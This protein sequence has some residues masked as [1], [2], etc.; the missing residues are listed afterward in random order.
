MVNKKDL[1]AGVACMRKTAAFL[2][3]WAD[4]LE[5]SL[6]KNGNRKVIAEDA[7]AV[8]PEAAE[9]VA[10]ELPAAAEEKN[11]EPEELTL[12]FM[13]SYLGTRSAAGLKTQVCALICSYGV[14]KLSE[15]D[16]V[17]YPELLAAVKGLGGPDA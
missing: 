6:E 9:P 14:S 7:A 11:A 5:S 15:L 16:P 8:L 4:D 1:R 3:Q 10:A 12:D 13:R 17:H 2:Q